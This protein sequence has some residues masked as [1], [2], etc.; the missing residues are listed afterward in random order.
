MGPPTIQTGY[1]CSI[2]FQDNITSE[3]NDSIRENESTVLLIYRLDEVFTSIAWITDTF[4]RN[5]SN[6]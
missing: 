1:D 5:K 3:H 2:E 6:I 4:A